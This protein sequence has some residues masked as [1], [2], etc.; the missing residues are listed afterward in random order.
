M[1]WSRL[2]N[3]AKWRAK[4]RV[5]SFYEKCFLQSTYDCATKEKKEERS[6]ETFSINL[7]VWYNRTQSLVQQIDY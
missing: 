7:S 3:G 4:K 6:G 2:R 1:T 5:W